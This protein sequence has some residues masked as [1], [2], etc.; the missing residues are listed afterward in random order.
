MSKIKETLSKLN[1]AKVNA[2]I[3]VEGDPRTRPG[4]EMVRNA[5]MADL[6]Q[7]RLDYRAAL[8]EVMSVTLVVGPHDKVEKFK[9]VVEDEGS[10]IMVENASALYENLAREVE[11]TFGRVREWTSTQHSRLIN[12][13]TVAMSKY[14]ILE[15]DS[16]PMGTIHTL[17]SFEDLVALIKR[18]VYLAVGPLLTA[19]EIEEAAFQEAEAVDYSP[20]ILSVVV[21]GVDDTDAKSLGENFSRLFVID[22][23]KSTPTKATLIST[24]KSIQKSNPRADSA[25]E[26]DKE[27]E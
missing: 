14:G 20:P 9:E 23:E 12:E 17:D 15:M 21:F 2:T 3:D 22:L 13:L 25:P 26:D 4:R 7:L 5:A 16:P 8:R 19:L 27:E 10:S 1:Q 18:N 24:Y 6:P 11:T